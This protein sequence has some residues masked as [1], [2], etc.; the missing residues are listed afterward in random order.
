M[1]TPRSKPKQQPMDGDLTMRQSVAL[2][3]ANRIHGFTVTWQFG[4]AS[5]E[6]SAGK[7]YCFITRDGALALKLPAERTAPLLES[8]SASLLKM[9][10]RTMKEWLVWPDPTS[11]EAV[12]LLHEAK[13]YVEALPPTKPKASKKK[14][15]PSKSAITKSKPSVKTKLAK[16]KL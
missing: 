8:G 2:A 7:V 14:A 5:F 1:P 13:A 4:H 9:G 3:L 16:K 12:T 15:P 11:N 10:S 6:T